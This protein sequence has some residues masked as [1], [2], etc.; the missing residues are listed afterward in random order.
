MFLAASGRRGRKLLVLLG[1][2]ADSKSQTFPPGE[3]RL[4]K[5]DGELF[6]LDPHPL[7]GEEMPQLMEKNDKAEPYDE[8][9]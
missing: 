6:D 7:G 1:A 9:Y 2:G 3:H 8:Q 4:T 5:S